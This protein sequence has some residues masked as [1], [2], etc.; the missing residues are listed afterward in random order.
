MDREFQD[1]I[2]NGIDL[3]ARRIERR[4]PGYRI[5]ISWLTLADEMRE[6]EL[7]ALGIKAERRDRYAV[8]DEG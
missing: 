5:R 7:A 4:Y 1:I 2:V 3:I 6:G 8:S